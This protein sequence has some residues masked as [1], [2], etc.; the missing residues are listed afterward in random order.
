MAITP[1][2]SPCRLF[3]F[4]ATFCAIAYT[5]DRKMQEKGCPISQLPPPITHHRNVP[6]PECLSTCGLACERCQNKREHRFKYHLVLRWAVDARRF[7]N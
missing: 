7:P 5:I 3:S 4:P 1:P 2:T 6:L